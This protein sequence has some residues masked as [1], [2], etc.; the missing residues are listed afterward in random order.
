MDNEQAD[1]KPPHYH[2]A[3]GREMVQHQ[4][5]DA[6]VQCALRHVID[7]MSADQRRQENNESSMNIMSY[8]ARATRALTDGEIKERVPSIF[9]GRAREDVSD[10]Y[11]FIPTGNIL[12]GMRDEGW[13]P[14]EVA[15]QRVKS[16][17]SPNRGF[18]KHMIRFAQRD[19][20]DKFQSQ[21]D[22]VVI[23]SHDRTSGYQLYGS[24][25]RLICFNGLV[26]S[27]DILEHMSIRHVGFNPDYVIT[28]SLDM[29]RELPKL[30]EVMAGW[31]DRKMTEAERLALANEAIVI[32]WG[33]YSK[34]PIGAKLLLEPR[35][36]ED[37]GSDLW[38]TFNVI[39]ENLMRGGMKD[40]EKRWE[41]MRQGNRRP[42]RARPVK[43]ID[44]NLRINRE[45]WFAAGQFL[46]N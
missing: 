39:Q 42:G 8:D 30:N 46:L 32:R 18:Q 40:R 7:S 12:D 25:M 9:A 31:Q 6:A 45:L 16:F 24:P 28:A 35:R 4:R 20:L 33:D 23:N 38:T 29:A 15:E 1:G 43:A 5:P 14:V 44:A 10:K 22:I 17:E 11:L 37:T 34:A 41:A 19:S 13:V 36:T 27:D 3:D 2:A 21:L 26:V